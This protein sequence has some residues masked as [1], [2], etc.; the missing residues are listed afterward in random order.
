[1]HFVNDV[2]P[3]GTMEGGKLDVFTQF[4]HIVHA[5]VGCPVDFNDIHR[6]SSGNFH[7]AGTSSAG[8]TGRPLFAIQRF[9]ENPGDSGFSDPSHS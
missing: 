2:Y 4:T 5:G 3:I 1:M 8:V 9:R 6:V 7:A